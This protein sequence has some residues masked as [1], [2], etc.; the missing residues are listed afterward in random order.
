MNGKKEGNNVQNYTI[1][2]IPA[3][4]EQTRQLVYERP[5]KYGMFKILQI[6]K[7][8]CLLKIILI[9][10]D[11]SLIEVISAVKGSVRECMDD[12]FLDRYD[13]ETI[14]KAISTDG[15]NADSKSKFS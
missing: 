10:S 2:D 13:I 15:H 8:D 6:S 1:K 12:V 7:I 11:G 9:N 4:F 3:E 5:Q 14:K